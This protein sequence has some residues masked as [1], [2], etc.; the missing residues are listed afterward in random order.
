MSENNNYIE[1]Q[2][3]LLKTINQIN[4]FLKALGNAKRYKIL[5]LLLNSPKNSNYLMNEL[6]IGKTALANHLKYLKDNFLVEKVKHGTY[7]LTQDS[8]DLLYAITDIYRKSKIREYQIIRTTQTQYSRVYQRA[9]R[10]AWKHVSTEPVYEPCS[11]SFLGAFTG[12]FKSLGLKVSLESI[13][14]YSGYAFVANVAKDRLC[15]SGITALPYNSWEEI[16][17]GIE[18]SFGWKIKEIGDSIPYPNSYPLDSIDKNRARSLFNQIKMEIDEK[19]RPIILW[20]LLIPEYG[21]IN[22]YDGENYICSTYRQNSNIEEAP[23]HF[24]TLQSPGSLHAFVIEDNL[25]RIPENIDQQAISRALSISL[26]YKSYPGYI[27][28]PEIFNHWADVL[29][30]G[31]FDKTSYH[32]N[33]YLGGCYFEARSIV[34]KFLDQLIDKYINY[35]Q[36]E[37]LEYSALEYGQVK[38][39]LGKFV[40]LFPFKLEGKITESKRKKSI[41]LLQAITPYEQSACSYL[42]KAVNV[43][44]N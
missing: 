21:I 32:A 43:W 30:L 29:D 38:E 36:S 14:A 9:M 6:K 40:S 44:K 7:S 41:E 16:M 34:V 26:D 4:P 27:S 20:G 18:F 23:V 33:S 11:I 10:G 19:N 37:F 24:T 8:Q 22:G 31:K 5:I 17:R 13:G 12:V 3:V 25:S 2:N 15:P 1:L 39:L 28:G 35:P 42:E